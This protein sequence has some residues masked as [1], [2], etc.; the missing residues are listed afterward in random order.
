MTQL[1]AD[2]VIIGG[3][4][5]GSGAAHAFAKR[6]LSVTLI[7]AESHLA[8]KASGNAWGLF[9]PYIATQSSPPGTLYARGFDFS[10]EL[11][12]TNL[13]ELI[14][15]H[16]VG[17]IQLPATK[18]LARLLTE[19]APCIGGTSVRRVS[20]Q[21]GSELAG[22]PLL[23]GGFFMPN[24][25]YCKP[26]RVTECL[27]HSSP[28]ISVR[29]SESVED[30]AWDGTTWRITLRS[31]N[32]ISSPLVILCGAH[33][34]TKLDIASWVPLE[35]IRGQTTQAL[36]STTSSKLRTVISY[37]GYVTPQCDNLH[38]VGAHYRHDDFDTEPKTA[39]T[40]EVLARLHR[41]LPATG[42][43]SAVSSRVCFRAS[44]HDRMP[45][46][47]TLPVT[48]GHN[49]FLNA[50]HGSR[51][52]L[53][54]PLGGEVVARIALKESLADLS[55]AAAIASASRLQK[56]M[57]SPPKENRSTQ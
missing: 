29:V 5:A 49:I 23:T 41:A 12:T 15:Y 38:F 51:G 14:S 50:G 32:H 55:D 44:T 52:L 46:I 24:A 8:A 54:A 56:K 43:L 31:G 25:G 2:V 57:P 37:D 48:T 7:E 22:L 39:D 53:T 11:F 45:Y 27:A 20:V 10:R 36:A 26:I 3:G 13:K 1:L 34:I 19:E 28:L 35:A 18:R 6:G 4:L 16:E 42:H 30:V 21:E 33:E 40:D 17:A 47:G 9:M